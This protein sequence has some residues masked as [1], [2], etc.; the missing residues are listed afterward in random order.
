MQRIAERLGK[1]LERRGL[2]VRDA[3]SSFLALG[4]ESGDENALAELQG[5]SIPYRIAVGPQKGRKA[6]Q[7]NLTRYHGVFAPNHP[8]AKVVPGRE[9]PDGAGPGTHPL[10]HVSM[11]WAKRL[12]R[13]FGIEVERCDQ[14]GGGVKIIAAI[15]NPAVIN[16]I[17]DHLGISRERPVN[18]LA[19]GPPV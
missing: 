17:L 12:K 2:L 3:E 4:E 1:H 5:H 19:R 13:V 9:R 10:R 18:R 6:P 11:G 15:E 14:C 16:K 7:V 8:W